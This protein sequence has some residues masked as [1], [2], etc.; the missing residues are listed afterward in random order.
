MTASTKPAA[1]DRD[2]DLRKI[3]LGRIAFDPNQPRKTIDK[4]TLA[5]LGQSL[6]AGQVTAIRVRPRKAEEDLPPTIEWVLINGERRL[7]AAALVGL[8]MLR[9]EVDWRAE[10][11]SADVLLA[12]IVENL[13]REDLTAVDEAAGIRDYIARTGKKAREVADVIGKN[14]MYVSLAVSMERLPPKVVKGLDG[15]VTWRHLRHLVRLNDYPEECERVAGWMKAEGMT[16]RDLED[17]VEGELSQIKRLAE[18]EEAA[19]AGAKPDAAPASGSLYEATP[20]QKQERLDKARLT[21]ARKEVI[22]DQADELARHV[23]DLAKGIKLP[24]GMAAA[25]A[26]RVNVYDLWSLAPKTGIGTVKAGGRTDLADL[27]AELI[28]PTLPGKW[29][30]GMGSAVNAGGW[31][32]DDEAGRHWLAFCLWASTETEGFDKLLDEA[33]VGILKDRDAET[34]AREKERAK[35]IAEKESKAA[36]AAAKPAPADLVLRCQKKNKDGKP[37]NLKF[38]VKQGRGRRPKYCPEHRSK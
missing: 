4:A 16:A 6:K 1:E 5:E 34:A 19:K 25:L 32:E 13:Q 8:T 3:A 33:A 38:H 11:A 31:A 35:R 12:Q 23:V 22:R 26:G 24:D 37:C 9:A 18:R 29:S 14:Q 20:K 15:D 28:V 36:A 21:R 7:R 2:L 30:K 27:V 17:A 10:P